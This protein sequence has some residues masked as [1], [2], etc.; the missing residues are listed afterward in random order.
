MISPVDDLSSCSQSLCL[1]AMSRSL[2]SAC[3]VHEPIDPAQIQLLHR[4]NQQTIKNTRQPSTDKLPNLMVRTDVRSTNVETRSTRIH[5][6]NY[7]L[8]R[9]HIK[10][11]PQ[12]GV[13]FCLGDRS[14][15][16]L[17]ICFV[18]RLCVYVH[19]HTKR[20]TAQAHRNSRAQVHEVGFIWS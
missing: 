1:A 16:L 3:D 5:T 20:L 18:Q 19:I 4:P 6:S 9:M 17:R 15:G 7:T 11:C 8:T 2:R 13:V 14:D 10:N 12:A